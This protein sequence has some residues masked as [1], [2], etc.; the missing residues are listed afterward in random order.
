MKPIKPVLI[1]LALLAV[2]VGAYLVLRLRAKEPQPSKPADT[3][4]IK[5]AS[6][7]PNYHPFAPVI[8]ELKEHQ[9][10]FPDSQQL[11]PRNLI[12]RPRTEEEE[13]VLDEEIAFHSFLENGLQP[14]MPV[15]VANQKSGIV[16]STA[17]DKNNK[18]NVMVSFKDPETGRKIDTVPFLEGVGNDHPLRLSRLQFGSCKN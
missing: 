13:F 2:A 5:P 1:G 14:G 16:T 4:A 8:K 10:R 7:T 9:N 18:I 11:A 3:P 15:C 17:M 6:P 12:E